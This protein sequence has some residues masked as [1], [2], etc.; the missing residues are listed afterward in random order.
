M[1]TSPAQ[2]QHSLGSPG[3][4]ALRQFVTLARLDAA[5]LGHAA[6]PAFGCLDAPDALPDAGY[7]VDRQEGHPAAV[8]PRTYRRP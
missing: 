2:V 1:T 5:H 8:F 4:H 7:W 6:L 3:Q